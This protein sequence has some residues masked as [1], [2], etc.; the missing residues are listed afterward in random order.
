MNTTV[1]FTE[2]EMD[3]CW[4]LGQSRHNQ[5]RSNGS[6]CRLEQGMEK[7]PFHID[8]IGALGELAYCKAYGLPVSLVLEDDRQSLEALQQGDINHNGVWVDI[9]TSEHETA[10]L[11][12]PVEKKHRCKADY[13]CLVVVQGNTAVVKGFCKSDNFM[14][15]ENIGRLRESRPL[16]ILSQDRLEREPYFLT[17]NRNRGFRSSNIFDFRTSF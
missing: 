5:A 2:E 17:I 10:R 15:E 7:Q 8:Y 14:R 9:K 11:I 13:L 6:V 4:E 16:Y 1:R 3:R 12:Y